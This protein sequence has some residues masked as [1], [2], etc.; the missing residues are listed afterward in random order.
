MDYFGTILR[1][2]VL[3]MVQPCMDAETRCLVR[4]LRT[5]SLHYRQHLQEPEK[6]IIEGLPQNARTLN[7]LM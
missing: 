2:R 5:N 6:G 4:L 3:V 7:R 1:G